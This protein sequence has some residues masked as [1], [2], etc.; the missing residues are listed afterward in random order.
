M[1][2]IQKKMTLYTRSVHTVFPLSKNNNPIQPTNPFLLVEKTIFQSNPPTQSL[3]FTLSYIYIYIYQ[4]T[5]PLLLVRKTIIQANLPIRS[6]YFTLFIEG[7]HEKTTV[8]PIFSFFSQRERKKYCHS[9][10]N[11]RTYR[12]VYIHDGGGGRAR[13]NNRIFLLSPWF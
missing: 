3:F 12:G 7:G 1:T 10:E 13:R 5:N 2:H 6:Q 9:K 4:P 8:F 11:Q